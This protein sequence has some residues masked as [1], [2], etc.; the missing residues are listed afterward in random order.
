M[1]K[2]KIQIIMLAMLTLVLSSCEDWLD[3][4][5]DPNN[6]QVGRVDLLLPS[7]EAHIFTYFSG[8]K[9][10]SIGSTLGTVMHQVVADGDEYK[11][12]STDFSINESF[13][14][15]YSGALTD[16]EE[17]IRIGSE[18]DDMQYVGIAKILKA[19]I[20]S[21]YVD[22]WGN[23][24]FT[25]ANRMPEI[26]FPKYD[27]GENIY[28]T[29]LKLIDEGVADIAKD[30][31]GVALLSGND[32]VYAGDTK[33]WVKFANSLKLDMYNKIRL[34]SSFDATAL[35]AVKALVSEGNFIDSKSEFELV[36]VNSKSP[37]NRNPMYVSEYGDASGTS[38][39]ISPW[40]YGAMMGKVGYVSCREGVVDPRV[41]YYFYRQVPRTDGSVKASAIDFFDSANNFYSK[42]FG[43]HNKGKT[44]SG[45][46]FYTALG[47]YP[48]GGKYDDGSLKPGDDS[49]SDRKGSGIAPVRLLS[50][51]DILYVRAELALVGH[52]T[53]NAETLLEQAIKA[54]FAKV[55]AVAAL[56]ASGVPA[57]ASANVQTYVDAIKLKY[58]AGNKLEVI[59]TEKWISDFANPLI[60]YNDYRRTGFPKL[61]DPNNDDA[62][63]PDDTE[64]TYTSY[65]YPVSMP[66]ANS[67]ITANKN[68]DAQR[69]IGSDRVFWDVN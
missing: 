14:S 23:I 15:V 7:V 47:V 50:S 39:L 20:Y 6:S 33:K 27:K 5:E 56:D 10:A 46:K 45:F 53:E 64:L 3:V 65:S 25:E 31:K 59:I 22:V 54:S 32:L 66:Y 40:F 2:F 4:N 8:Y 57:I 68:A 30:S 16:V 55:N 34:H 58:N 69:T 29:L 63:F 48:C 41:P 35:A 37:E 21:V 44:S 42:R 61:Y 19:Y 62:M 52:T 13:S 9:S 1:K 36:Y 12:T 49:K 67:S 26:M 38:Y 17:I 28:P 43:S 24:P 18:G 11:I 51:H 60:S